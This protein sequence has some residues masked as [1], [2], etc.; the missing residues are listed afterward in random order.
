MISLAFGR[1]YVGPET[2][3]R[4]IAEETAGLVALADELAGSDRPLVTVS[5]TP[6]VPGRASTEVDAPPTQGPVGGRGRSVIALLARA[7]SVRAMAVRM[8]RMVH[9]EGKGGFAGS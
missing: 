5:G 3:A 4:S 9:N 2:L 6:R 8:P 1:D 7:P